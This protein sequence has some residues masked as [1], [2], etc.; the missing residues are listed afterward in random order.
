MNQ[1]YAQL[2][3][4][5]LEGRQVVPA[6]LQPYAV[7]RGNRCSIQLRGAGVIAAEKEALRQVLR[8]G[9]VLSLYLSPFPNDPVGIEQLQAFRSLNAR[10]PSGWDASGCGAAVLDAYRSAL[11]YHSIRPKK[12][13]SPPPA[14]T[15]QSLEETGWQ[16][17]H[18]CREA[19]DFLLDFLQNGLHKEVSAEALPVDPDLLQW[20]CS[21]LG[22]EIRMPA[23]L[24]EIT[25]LAAADFTPGT[26]ACPGWLRPAPG[27]WRIL[28]HLP[29]L[30][31]LEFPRVCIENFSF[32]LRC[33]QLKYLDLSAS[34]FY[35]GS[36]LVFLEQ[37]QTLILPASELRD[38]SFLKSCRHLVHLDVSKSNFRDCSLLEELPALQSVSLPPK[39]VLLH[40]EILDRLAASVRTEEPEAEEPSGPAC[41]FSKETLPVGRNG[42]YAQAVAVN[43]RI[44]RGE[45]ITKALVRRL[46]ND[47]KAGRLRTLA[48][49]ADQDLEHLVLTADIRDGWAALALQD[50]ECGAC[51]QPRNPRYAD[52]D[53]PAPPKIGGQSP[54]PKSLAQEDLRAAAACVECYLQTGKLLP[55]LLWEKTD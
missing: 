37:L 51:Y 43:G 27:D 34:S 7:S 28:G 25:R 5:S 36:D 44:C 15:S 45:K 2:V 41:Y 4:L 23:D 35:D 47:L 29:H 3:V 20:L 13:S 48:C 53:S 54:V 6:S 33:R 19:A 21:A 10:F 50:F 39:C 18:T 31:L 24:T 26:P 49:S 42:F 22:R 55:E 11:L 12:P 38:F 1:P 16:I 52:C 32:L 9:G 40:H 46:L 8:Q 14:E 17:F 30:E